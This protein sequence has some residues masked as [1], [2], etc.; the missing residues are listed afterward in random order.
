[1]DLVAVRK[2]AHALVTVPA[3]AVAAIRAADSRARVVAVNHHVVVARLPAS[4]TLAASGRL[5]LAVFIAVRKPALQLRFQRTDVGTGSA[6]RA[7]RRQ[8]ILTLTLSYAHLVSN[9]SG[10][11]LLVVLNLRS[12]NSDLR[13]ACQLHVRLV[14]WQVQ[15]F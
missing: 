9:Q 4:E 2:G 15:A 13:V 5:S 11:V 7:Q 12:G 1:M 3:S 10:V 14:V 6:F 8:T